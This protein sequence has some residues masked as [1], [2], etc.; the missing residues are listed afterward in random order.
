[1]RNREF[2]KIREYILNT[3]LMDL[4][5][6]RKLYQEGDPPSEGP[7]PDHIGPDLIGP[8]ASSRPEKTKAE[9]IHRLKLVPHP[10]PLSNTRYQVDARIASTLASKKAGKPKPQITL[11]THLKKLNLLD[12][13][14]EAPILWQISF[15]WFLKKY[16]GMETGL[17]GKKIS[18]F[19]FRMQFHRKMIFELWEHLKQLHTIVA[20]EKDYPVPREWITDL[21]NS[22]QKQ[23]LKEASGYFPELLLSPKPFNQ[24]KPSS[25][26]VDLEVE[27][28]ESI[29]KAFAKKQVENQALV[30]RVVAVLGSS[31]DSIKS[32]RLDTTPDA[33][34][35]NVRDRLP[36]AR[37]GKLQI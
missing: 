32:H 35:R 19:T 3:H 22:I 26:T 6:K 24:R 14:V 31:M 1:M 17:K 23:L 8:K 16:K 36:K 2:A 7:G 33:V 27:L 12:V 13:L 28:F 37:L 11:Y 30:Y 25:H 10:V 5:E 18:Q 20:T 21:E 34:R 4:E 15:M 9:I 29:H